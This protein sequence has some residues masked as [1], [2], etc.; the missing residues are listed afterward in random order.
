MQII[1]QEDEQMRILISS[2]QVSLGASKGHLHPAIEIGLELKRRG[3]EVGILP[4]PNPFNKTDREQI[5][6]CD[7]E[8]IDPP[9]LPD[10]V[11]R[12]PQELG[13]L[14]KHPSTTAQA[15]HSFLVAPLEHQFDD[16][17]KKIKDYNPDVIVYDL[18]VYAA[19]IAA[20]LLDI[21]DIGY[22]AGLKLIAPASLTMNYQ[23]MHNELAPA[24][25]GFVKKYAAN[26][27]F[28]HL[29]LLANTFQFVF[30]PNAFMA[31]M[32]N[33]V[34]RRTICAGSLPISSA[35]CEEDVFQ[36]DSDKDLT[37]LCFGSALD[38]ANYPEITKLIIKMAEQFNQHL[39]ISTQKPELIPESENMTVASYIPLPQLLKKASIFIHHGGA[40]TFSECLTL[41]VPQILI[42]L[43]TDQPIQAELLQQ[44][45]SG[46][47]IYPHEVTEQSLHDAFKKLL[48]Q[49]D[50][51]Q[52]HILEIKNLY[53]QSTGADVLS[54]LVEVIG[55]NKVQFNPLE[56][57]KYFQNVCAAEK[58]VVGI[59]YP[60][61]ED[62]I[63]KLI[64]LS[65]KINLPLYPIS[66]GMNYG[67]GSRLSVK[68]NHLVVDLS[69]MN[70]ILAFDADLGTIQIEP[71]VTQ[72]D[73]ADYLQHSN[74]DF[75]LNVTGSAA[76]SSV[77][78][79]ALDR[80]IAHYGSRVPEVMHLNLILGDGN[81][82][83]TD[84]FNNVYPHGLGPDC[85]G[86]FF[87]S[88]FGIV[89]SMTVRLLPKTQCV[90]MVTIEKN[91]TIPLK[92]FIN[93]LRIA[94][95]RQ[96][97]PENLH[98]SNYNRRL[99]VITPL[100]A[101]HN[102]ISLSEATKIAKERIKNDWAA[103]SSLRGER[104]IVEVQ[105]K[106]LNEF[107]NEYAKVSVLY[108]ADL[109]QTSDPFLLAIKGTAGHALGIPCS[110][111]L[112]S[113]GYSL[114]LSF[115]ETLENS[116][117]GTLFL[118]PAL[119]LKGDDF[120][121]VIE[122]IM[123]Q[124]QKYHFEPYMTFNLVEQIS[125]EGVIN[126][127]FKKSDKNAVSSAHAC[128]QETLTA[129]ENLGY[130]P[131]RLSIFQNSSYLC[132]DNIRN[133]IRSDLKSIFD[134]NNIISQGRYD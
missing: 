105:I 10:G 22:C 9:S 24:I 109:S 56:L 106:C 26:V 80:G 102:N 104:A 73:I 89:T 127:C 2:L 122:C 60:Q 133:K 97:L 99:S 90:A 100:I 96:L 66:R 43:T 59:V 82:F 19:P 47:S 27:E 38:P 45:K 8:V 37:V 70:R 6:R 129:L 36:Y 85:K 23:S 49:Q 92:E 31:K 114:E 14:A 57:E 39:I 112:L 40:N 25:N 30:T 117:I 64:K 41:G 51:I 94:K 7:F 113:L 87:Q 33:V 95:H 72:Q 21:P 20:R 83:S 34:P 78:G 124:F 68:D 88:N 4:L 120:V 67:L 101:R 69:K 15:Y 93:K 76:D 18:L 71:G 123:H 130:P 74:A 107:L 61:S 63:V 132:K 75:I 116:D 32:K 65:R 11:M 91:P 118:V 108:D 126:L 5:A 3:H 77:V 62:E 12:S 53:Q 16:I 50:P 110:D 1:K 119:P 125:L 13:K 29:E 46:I 35:R 52:Q 134:P 55:K 58:K 28:H 54:D 86:L 121:N 17:L 44:S 131:M 111:A 115:T 103:T 81:K 98:I 42:P 84:I 79:N 128:V 48:D